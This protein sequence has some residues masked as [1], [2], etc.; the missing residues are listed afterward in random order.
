M[1]AI[2]TPEMTVPNIVP[3]PQVEERLYQG[4]VDGELV[5]FPELVLSSLIARPPRWEQTQVLSSLASSRALSD[6]CCQEEFSAQIGR[7]QLG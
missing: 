5:F 4:L 6:A 3:V 1:S 2:R 7:R